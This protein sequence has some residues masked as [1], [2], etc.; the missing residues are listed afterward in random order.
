MQRIS[1]GGV[2]IPWRWNELTFRLFFLQNDS[3]VFWIHKGGKEVR[4]RSVYH[5]QERKNPADRWRVSWISMKNWELLFI[6]KGC[7]CK[8]L[9]DCRWRR[10][11]AGLYRGREWAYSPCGFRFCN[12]WSAVVSHEYS[13]HTG[14]SSR[15]AVSPY[16]CFGRKKFPVLLIAGMILVHRIL[17]NCHIDLSDFSSAALSS[18][19][20]ATPP[21]SALHMRKSSYVNIADT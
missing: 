17:S 3:G 9:S 21:S 19:A 2:C 14:I 20:T 7:H 18:V 6:W 4:T 8:S 12:R 15:P 1:W 16:S 10:I 11:Y 5:D 13:V